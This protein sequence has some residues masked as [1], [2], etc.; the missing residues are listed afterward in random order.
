MT[1]AERYGSFLLDLDGVLYRA[2]QAVPGAAQTVQRLRDAG[3]GIAFVTNNSSRTP[4]EVADKLAGLGVG[5]TS[6]EVVTSAL[7]TAALLAR[8]GG[9]T[10]FVIG[11]TG[12][13]KALAEAGVEVLDGEPESVT[14]VVVGWDRGADYSKLRTASLLVE[15]GAHLV[16]TNADAAYPAPDGA[17][18]GAGALLAAVTTATGV[19]AEVVGKPHAPLFRTAIERA[20]REPAMSVGDRIDT[21]VAGAHALGLDTLLLFSGV[22]TPRDVVRAAVVPTYVGRDITTLFDDHPRVRPAT[23]SDADGMARLLREAGLDANGPFLPTATLVAD[24][25]GDVVGTVAVEFDGTMAHLRSLA[26]D[27][28]RRRAF[29]GT[30]LAAGAVAEA[31]SAGAD[32]VYIVTETAEDFFGRLGF[33]RVGPLTEL[34]LPFREH[35]TL[36]SETATTMRLPL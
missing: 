30:L 16:A 14:W 34:P 23:P 2:D 7:A 18:P 19:R 32:E 6:D 5:A 17:W 26:V 3:R 10:A 31:H 20:G 21:D 9:G 25:D 15:R 4:E 33:E 1:L 13:R 28:P 35:M 12:I 8:R 22:S 24:L 11:E 29:L 27:E 36:C